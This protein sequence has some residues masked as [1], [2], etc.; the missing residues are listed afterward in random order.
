L[1]R[2]RC[3]IGEVVLRRRSVTE[4][5]CKE[6]FCMCAFKGHSYLAPAPENEE[7]KDPAPAEDDPDDP[8]PVEEDADDPAP[9]END[10]PEDPAAATEDDNSTPGKDAAVP[11]DPEPTEENQG[12][13]PFDYD[14]WHCT[15]STH[16]MC[17]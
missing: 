10:D 2:R 13:F 15:T 5:F 9:V 6:T 12:R 8:E 16:C 4:A 1:F 14:A 7:P 17:N 3:V 11:K